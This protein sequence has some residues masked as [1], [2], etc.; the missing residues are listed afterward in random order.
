M[1]IFVSTAMP[2]KGQESYNSDLMVFLLGSVHTQMHNVSYCSKTTVVTV[3]VWEGMADGK[4]AKIP[5]S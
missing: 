1:W 4:A 3:C 2:T 5:S